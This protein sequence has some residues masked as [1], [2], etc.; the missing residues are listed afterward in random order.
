MGPQKPG[1]RF[2]FLTL[3]LALLS[4]NQ[5]WP[6]ALIIPKEAIGVR[7]IRFRGM[8]HL[9][10]KVKE[11]YPGSKII[12]E[13]SKSLARK[14]FQPLKEE[15][16]RPDQPSSQVLGWTFY[17]DKRIGSNSFVYEWKTDFKDTKNDVVSYT[18]Q[19]RDPI[20]KYKQPTYILK[21]SASELTVIVIYM[22][23]TIAEAMRKASVK[24]S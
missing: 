12:S 5:R 1:W 15:Y 24:K 10:Y 16:L 19:Y 18:L 6:D 13:I 17:E 2:L 7:H 9:S 14:G 3:A 11:R 20:E 4:C 22:P 21:P 8:D 23:Q